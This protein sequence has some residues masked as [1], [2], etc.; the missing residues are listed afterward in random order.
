MMKV[1]L[2]GKYP[3]GTYEAVR[4]LLPETEYILTA[5]DT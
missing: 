4:K 3:E 5:V 2:A 1:V